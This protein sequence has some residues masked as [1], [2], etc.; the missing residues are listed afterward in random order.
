MGFR[1]GLINPPHAANVWNAHLMGE[2]FT[3]QP[4]PDSG[5][6]GPYETWD[7][8][9]DPGG[10]TTLRV[11]LLDFNNKV[12]FDIR[13]LGPV[14]DGGD[15]QF[16]CLTKQL[17]GG[18][19][20]PPPAERPAFMEWIRERLVDIFKLFYW[21]YDNTA[22]W[23]WPF[24]IIS[25]PFYDIYRAF[26]WVAKHWIDFSDWVAEVWRRVQEAWDAD[27]ILGLL[28]MW[29]PWLYDIGEWFYAR[30]SWFTTAVGDWWASVSETVKGWIDIAWE[31]VLELIADIQVGLAQLWADLQWFFDHLMTFDEIIEWW[32]D[33][34]GNT[35][36]A[37]TRWGFAK[38]TDV[39][40]LILSAFIEREDFWAG[41]QDMRGAVAD[42]FTDPLE[43]LWNMF[44]DWFLGPEE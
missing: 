24:R 15:Y 41:W 6:L 20:A 13:N 10:S 16:N 35:A 11:W 33:W 29:F 32:K 9:S 8:P 27:G 44:T 14:N 36:A 18:V 23:V 25:I 5:W 37:I 7:Y 43:F 2:M 40:A 34:L 21:L 39:A 42:F 22:G 19:P 12:L 17:E 3:L 26:V 28:K 1:L 31:W 38:L 30:W 4:M